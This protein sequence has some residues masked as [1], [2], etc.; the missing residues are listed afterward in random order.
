MVKLQE[1]WDAGTWMC[2]IPAVQC[3]DKWWQNSNITCSYQIHVHENC[4]NFCT[5]FLHFSTMAWS[6]P[7]VQ[8]NGMVCPFSSHWSIGIISTENISM[9]T[10]FQCLTRNVHTAKTC[11]QIFQILTFPTHLHQFNKTV[12]LMMHLHYW[13]RHEQ[14]L[15]NVSH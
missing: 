5:G 7:S 3:T 9:W 8:Y 15:C 13:C 12:L 2:Q 10:Q 6:V 4:W 1:Q 11:D 14:T